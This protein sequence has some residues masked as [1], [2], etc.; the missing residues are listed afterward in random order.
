[1]T[2]I[3]PVS[4]NE[5]TKPHLFCPGCGHAIILKQLGFA[6]DEMGIPRDTTFGIDIGCS[7]LAWNFFNIDTIQTHHGRT[8]PVMAGYKMVKPK[9]VALAYMGEGGA[10]AIGLQSLLHA[11]FR[12]NPITVVV[13]NNENYAMTGGQMSPSTLPGTITATTPHGKTS[14][15]GPGMKGPELVRG[16]ADKTAFIT[17]ASVSNPMGIKMAL[18]RAI[19][20]QIKNNSFSFVEILSICPTNWKTNAEASFDKLKELESYYAIGEVK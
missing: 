18:K 13:V 2:T 19:E 6:V 4:W 9:R 14:G 17:R 20:N 7:L 10:Y 1:M 16:V 12:N 3:M 11:A 8:V 15:F 5:K